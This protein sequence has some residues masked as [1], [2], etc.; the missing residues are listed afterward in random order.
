MPREESAG[1]PAKTL[2]TEAPGLAGTP[3][4]GLILE[5]KPFTAMPV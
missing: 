4:K 1:K 2:H 3:K 5:G